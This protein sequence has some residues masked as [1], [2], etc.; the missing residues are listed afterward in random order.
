VESLLGELAATVVLIA[1]QLKGSGRLTLQLKG[2]GAVSLLLV[3]CDE[4]LRLCGMA[5]A[6]E[7]CPQGA[8]VPELLLGA[9]KVDNA[10]E[11]QLL[12]TLE[13]ERSI[14][15]S[16]VP[17][18]GDTVSAIFSHYL[19]QSE[20][21]EARLFLAANEAV[22]AGLFLQKMPGAD[23]LD[24][25]GWTRL[26]SLAET[27]RPEEL[28]ELEAES[29]LFRLFSEDALPQADAPAGLALFPRRAVYWHC[30]DNREKLIALIKSWGRK[31]AEAI[32]TERGAIE[33]KDEIGNRIYR[34]DADDLAKIFA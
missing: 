25:D 28:L 29:L 8:S 16:I 2:N 1:A 3:D 19:M 14:Y 4:A 20:Q 22:S 32:L 21:Q 18:A 30:P 9:G 7:Q 24:K 6:E 26:T 34:F 10:G 31:E 23:T 15:Q 11:G 27:V 33:I 13:Q 12:L 5:R 17:L